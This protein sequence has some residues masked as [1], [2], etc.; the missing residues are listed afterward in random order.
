MLI[1]CG[2]DAVAGLLAAG[3]GEAVGIA[4][5]VVVLSSAELTTLLFALECIGRTGWAMEVGEEEI[6]SKIQSLSLVTRV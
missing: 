3:A 4:A 5:A 6:A 2:L 1:P